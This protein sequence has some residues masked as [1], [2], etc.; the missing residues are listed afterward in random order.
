MATSCLFAL[1][2]HGCDEY[3]K[4]TNLTP[5][6]TD[7]RRRQRDAGS[8][9][10]LPFRHSRENEIASQSLD[11][12]RATNLP[13][14][15][16]AKRFKDLKSAVTPLPLIMQL[17]LA[18]RLDRQLRLQGPASCHSAVHQPWAQCV[19][20]VTIKVAFAFF[21]FFFRFYLSCGQTSWQVK[22]ATNVSI[23]QRREAICIICR[24][25]MRE[26]GRIFLADGLLHPKE[27]RRRKNDKALMKVATWKC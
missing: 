22:E 4:V 11:K 15:Q 7:G 18:Q 5:R 12:R 25:Q 26:K 16:T 1:M 14:P 20:R 19:T 8:A 2:T 23:P 27:K 21:F 9:R 6:W 10:S 17:P 3:S 13:A 24:A